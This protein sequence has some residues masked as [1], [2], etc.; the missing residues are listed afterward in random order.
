M[1]E[2]GKDERY[3]KERDKEMSNVLIHHRNSKGKKIQNEYKNNVSG[4]NASFAIRFA[5]RQRDWEKKESKCFPSKIVEISIST[6][7]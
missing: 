1:W 7:E 3:L 4:A 2:S 5:S 6:D